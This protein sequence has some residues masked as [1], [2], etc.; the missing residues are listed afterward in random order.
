MTISNLLN[1]AGPT[2][3][4]SDAVN[5]FLQQQTSDLLPAGGDMGVNTQVPPVGGDIGIGPFDWDQPYSMTPISP[6]QNN[7]P[8]IFGDQN[9]FPNYQQG[10]NLLA[11]YMNLN[12]QPNRYRG[13]SYGGRGYGN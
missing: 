11:P 6:N 1:I 5:Q 8:L 3:P 4:D 12:S 10:M 9:S 2:V 13:A 7:Q